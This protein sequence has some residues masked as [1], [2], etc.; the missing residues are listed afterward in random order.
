MGMIYRTNSH[1]CESDYTLTIYTY[2]ISQ[3][4]YNRD[5]FSCY[6]Q[7]SIV[8]K[9]VPSKKVPRIYFILYII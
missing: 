9:L 6:K 7:D 2:T 4:A 8:K 5:L 3:I 1:P